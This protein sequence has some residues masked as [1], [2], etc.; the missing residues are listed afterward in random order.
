[1]NRNQGVAVGVA[2][3][4]VVL[5]LVYSYF[6]GII[7]KPVAFNMTQS[8]S[9]S[10]EAENGTTTASGLGIKDVVLGAGEA[11][12]AGDTVTVN[13]IGTFTNGTKFDSSYDHGQPFT[14]VLGSGQVISGWDQGIVGMKV[15][16]KRD[17]VIPP[18]LGYGPNPVGPIPGNS[19]L[20]FEVELLNVSHAPAVNQ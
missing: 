5:F 4:A 9:S 1:M 12:S 19:T 11:A 16:G 3:A 10:T 18:N 17:L 7:Q 8:N 20:L 2:I 15:G 6:N 13:Y 14:F